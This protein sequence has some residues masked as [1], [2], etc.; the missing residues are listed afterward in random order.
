M[1]LQV[2]QPVSTKFRASA[3]GGGL[4]PS[5]VGRIEKQPLQL[6]RAVA[7]APAR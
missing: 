2:T 7:P 1:H 5:F 3:K 6:D 4:F